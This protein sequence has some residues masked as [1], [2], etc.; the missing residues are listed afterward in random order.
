M[1]R[2]TPHAIPMRPVSLALVVLS[3]RR[4]PTPPDYAGAIRAYR[5]AHRF[6]VGELTANSQ[7]G[8]HTA[9]RVPVPS[10]HS[11]AGSFSSRVVCRCASARAAEN[12]G[13]GFLTF[14]E[15]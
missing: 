3:I 8:A 6:A 4:T 5:R 2:S 15:S 9:R 13:A 14:A 1:I 11:A 10:A 7:R 12:S